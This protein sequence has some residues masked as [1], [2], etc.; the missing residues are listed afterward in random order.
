MKT[1]NYLLWNY[2]RPEDHTDRSYKVR[3]HCLADCLEIFE[4]YPVHPNICYLR[5]GLNRERDFLERLNI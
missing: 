3:D 4:T 5:K 1:E 2:F